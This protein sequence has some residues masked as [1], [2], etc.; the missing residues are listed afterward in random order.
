MRVETSTNDPLY[1]AGASATTSIG[2]TTDN[3]P[4]WTTV[5]GVT[6]AVVTSADATTATAVTA[7]PTSGQKLV[8]TDIIA[9]SDTAMFLLFQ[10]ETSGTV[11]FKI[12]LPANGTVQLTPRGKVKLATA[13]KK[14][15]VDASATGNI[16]VTALYYSEA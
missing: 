9:S 12:W 7:A 4:A 6:S 13:D 14:L 1:V 16:A 11:L 2:A 3:G 5:L 8:I 10:E 15:L